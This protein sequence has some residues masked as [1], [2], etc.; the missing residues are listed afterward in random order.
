MTGVQTCALPI[1]ADAQRELEEGRK[2]LQDAR[3]KL[4]DGWVEYEDGLA[5]LQE[6]RETLAQETTKAQRELNDAYAE[7]TDGE[8][9]YADGVQE[10]EDGKAEAEEELSD[11]R[12][13][14]SD[15]RRDISE[16]ENCKWYLLS[17]NTNMGYVSFQQD[18]ERMGN[19]ASVF[20]LIFFLVAAL[21]CLTTMTRM[22]E[23]QRVQIGGLKALGYS[24]NAIAFKYVGYGFL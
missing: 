22:V 1:L 17:R 16:I 3:E 14:L 18:A 6:A 9:E 5:E 19:L 23:E 15:A 13:K 7:L 11:A 8:A 21:V 2:D 20:P 10:Y 24:R 4:D 12:R